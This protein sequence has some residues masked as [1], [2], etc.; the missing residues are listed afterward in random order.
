M[1]L[2][3]QSD[4]PTGLCSLKNKEERGEKQE[5]FLEECA[6]FVFCAILT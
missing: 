5:D 3:T 2:P 1:V 4:R 6:V